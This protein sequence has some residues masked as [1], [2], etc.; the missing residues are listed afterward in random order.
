MVLGNR[1]AAKAYGPPFTRVEQEGWDEQ[2]ALNLRTT[3]AATKAAIP[4]LK[5]Q[6]QGAIVTRTL[7]ERQALLE[8]CHTLCWIAGQAPVEV[9]ELDVR[10][11]P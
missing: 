5:Q 6:S 3:F 11:E 2:M 4:H 7:G 10:F 1:K 9:E 8:D